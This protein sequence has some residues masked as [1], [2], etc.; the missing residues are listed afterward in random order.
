MKGNRL[1]KSEKLRSR[2]AINEVFSS[3]N[4][5][6]SFP[7]RVVFRE[8]DDGVAIPRF[9]ITV[10]KKKIRTAVRRVLIRRRIREAYRLNRSILNDCTSGSDNSVEMAFIYL[11]NGVADYDIIELKMQD[12]LRKISVRIVKDQTIQG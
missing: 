3:G 10:P 2:T 8:V 6:I 5:V 7:L 1:Y 9:M 12:L 11:D 4:S